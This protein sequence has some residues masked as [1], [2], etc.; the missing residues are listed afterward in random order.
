MNKMNKKGFTLIEMLVVIAIIAVLVSI[1]V[2]VVSNSTAKAAAATNAANLR[3]IKAEV[4]TAMLTTDKTTGTT[5][6]GFTIKGD[7]TVT[8]T[9][10]G[11]VTFKKVTNFGTYD[12][13]DAKKDVT[14]E[15]ATN[16][17]YTVKY[18]G[19]TIDDW[20]KVAAGET[21]VTAPAAGG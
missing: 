17:G 10:D 12:G 3:S 15:P 16:G 11:T 2:P 20:A 8:G 21:A 19:K 9:F 5:V 13:S 4:T 6:R 1:I 7:G 14:I 18:A